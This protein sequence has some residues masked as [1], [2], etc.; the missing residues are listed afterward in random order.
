MGRARITLMYDLICP[1]DADLS[2]PRA[3]GANRL[4]AIAF[5]LFTAIAAVSALILEEMEK[6]LIGKGKSNEIKL[7]D[8]THKPYVVAIVS[9]EV[10]RTWLG[11]AWGNGFL[12]RSNRHWLSGLAMHY[13][14][15]QQ[16]RLKDEKYLEQEQTQVSPTYCY[17]YGEYKLTQFGKDSRPQNCPW[18]PILS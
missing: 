8:T 5:R 4:F 12:V 10:A 18:K 2:Q 6:L 11:S 15:V 14:H 1:I 9:P 13:G 16:D 3:K 17:R 7:T